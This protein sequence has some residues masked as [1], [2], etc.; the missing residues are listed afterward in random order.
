MKDK[1]LIETRNGRRPYTANLTGAY[2]VDIGI[3]CVVDGTNRKTTV[4][5]LNT[6]SWARATQRL[7]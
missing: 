7:L 2:K 5:V 6:Y 3:I 1:T 4:P